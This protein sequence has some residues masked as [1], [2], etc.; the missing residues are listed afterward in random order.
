MEAHSSPPKFGTFLLRKIY[1]Q[2]LFD[3]ISGDLDELYQDR[4]ATEGKFLAGFNYLIDAALS[5]RNYDLKYKNKVTQNNSTAMLK[6]YIKITLRT[7]SKNKVYSGLNI[8]GLALGIAA[9]LFILQYVSYERSYDKF[10]ENHENLYRILYK[11]HQNGELNIDCAAAVPRVGPFMKENMK[12]VVDYARAYPQSGVITYNNINFREDRIHVVDPSFLKIFTFPLVT[13]DVNSCLTEPNTVV[14]SETA[15]RKYFGEDDPIGKMISLDGEHSLGVTGVA[16][17]VPNNSHIKFDFLISFE[18]LNNRTRDENGNVPSETSWGW[19]DYNSYVLLESGANIEEYDKRFSELLVEER[20]ED[21]E[22]YNMKDEFPLQPITDIHLYSNLLQESEP[23]EQGDGDAVFF[24][25]IIAFFILL[26]AWINYVNL[27][28]A[29]SIER[30]KEVGVRKT[31]GAYKKQLVYQFLAESFILNFIALILGLLIVVLGIQYFNQLTGSVLSLSFLLNG[32]FWLV[33]GA[34]YL[35]GSL[36]SGIYPAFILSSYKP[37]DVLKGKLSTNR[38]GNQLRRVL[39]IFQFASSVT[40]IAGT[41][42][43]YQQLDHMSSIDLGFD[44]T[45]TLVIKGPQ[46][47]GADSLYQSTMQA[48]KNE[49]IKNP[50]IEFLTSATTVPGTEIF[51]TRGIRRATGGDDSRKTSYI[52]AV[53]YDYFPA[54]DIDIIAGRNFGRTFTTDTGSVILNKAGIKMLGFSSPEEAVDN[55]IYYGDRM[56]TIV[57]VVEDYNQ[58]SVKSEVA[59]IMFQLVQNF[60]QFFTLKLKMGAYQEAF[61]KAETEYARFFPGNPFDYFFLDDH[62]NRQYNNERTFSKVFTLFAG[63]AIIVACLGLFGLSSFSALQRTKEIG[64]R[65]AIGANISSIIFLLSREFLLLVLIG[66]LIAWPVSYLVMNT[67]LDNFATRIDIGIPVYLLSG[68][69]VI[70]IAAITVGYKTLIT[71]K[72]NPVRALRYE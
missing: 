35:V 58:M 71:A 43:V 57:G 15:A 60:T 25:T 16:K 13:G 1:G 17:D 18:T 44:M 66:N 33:V 40:L 34:I 6:N 62:F 38:A 12:E 48:F 21:R 39:V 63:F 4:I 19:Y 26:I 52:A 69:A 8:M 20:R 9:C 11:V 36:F 50:E 42:V 47:F 64:I 28:T 3:E 22:Q 59:P 54:Y 14:I 68:F 55:R 7:L 56:K 72:T 70:L 23:E 65:K 51:W 31:M 67:W 49:I 30:A 5:I 53:D 24:L 32:T 61:D 37:T 45:E 41:M 10:H 29:R 2:E 27:S 46:V